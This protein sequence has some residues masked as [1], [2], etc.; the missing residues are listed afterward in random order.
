MH[1]I[2]L[3]ALFAA[4]CELIDD[5]RLELFGEALSARREDRARHEVELA[6]CNFVGM[7]APEQL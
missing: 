7:S 6:A 5:Q 4:V 2:V 1:C 3:E